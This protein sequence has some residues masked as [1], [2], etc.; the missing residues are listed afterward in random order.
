MVQSQSPWLVCLSPAHR[1]CLSFHSK[2]NQSHCRIKVLSFL[3][4]FP[5]V[6]FQYG[7]PSSGS[8]PQGRARSQLSDHMARRALLLAFYISLCLS[9]PTSPG[10]LGILVPP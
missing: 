7:S 2:E 4:Y 10:C 5:K 6:V 1:P 3:C 8:C 9:M